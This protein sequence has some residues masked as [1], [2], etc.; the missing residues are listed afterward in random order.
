MELGDEYTRLIYGVNRKDEKVWQELFDS[1]Y[2][3]LCNHAARILLDDQVTEDIVQEVFV[4]LW[5]GTAVFENEKALTVYLYRSVTNNALK[6]LRDRNTEEARLRLWSE[7]EQEMSEE[8]FSSVVREEVLRKLREL[9]DL[10]PGERRK[11][12]LM[13]MDGMSGE[14][15]LE[16]LASD[17]KLVKRPLVIGED[18]VLVGFKPEEWKTVLLK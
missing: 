6:Y 16:L 11:V 4:N 8:N 15:Q 2:E 10:L 12:I 13:S 7:V 9:I 1:Y 17:G 14:E 3:S 18:F 5:N